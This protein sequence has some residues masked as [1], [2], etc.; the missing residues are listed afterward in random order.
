MEVIL[1][2][3]TSLHTIST[4]R[5]NPEDGIVHSHRYGNLSSYIVNELLTSLKIKEYIIW[6]VALS[7][8]SQ[9]TFRRHMSLP[10]LGSK[11]KQHKK[12][13]SNSWQIFRSWRWRRHVSPKHWLTFNGLTQRYIPS[14]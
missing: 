2:S 7:I 8:E 3:E 9:S 13:V 14:S 1:S 12:P 4:Q 5:H 10:S 11:N 6:I